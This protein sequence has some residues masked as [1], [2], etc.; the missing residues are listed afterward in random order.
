MDLDT[1]LGKLQACSSQFEWENVADQYLRARPIGTEC[2]PLCPVQAVYYATITPE[3]TWETDC[4]E[5]LGISRWDLSMIIH[6]ADRNTISSK[7]LRDQIF[8]AVGVP[9]NTEFHFPD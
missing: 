4:A 2:L 1:F 7:A 6:A 9:N 5:I 3:R 8:K